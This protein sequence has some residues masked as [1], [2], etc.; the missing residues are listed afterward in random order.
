MTV[1]EN[2]Q[3]TAKGTVY[4]FRPEGIYDCLY[5]AEC[6]ED[7]ERFATFFYAP[8]DYKMDFLWDIGDTLASVYGAECISVRKG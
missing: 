7:G 5:L 1:I 8:S 3:K 6:T 4:A 2:I